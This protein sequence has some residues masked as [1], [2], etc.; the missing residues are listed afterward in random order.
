MKSCGRHPK[1]YV[2]AL[3][4]FDEFRGLLVG[5]STG[6]WQIWSIMSSKAEL[7]FT[8]AVPEN[9]LPV[10]HFGLVAPENDPHYMLY[11]WVT[12]SAKTANE[13]LEN[14]CTYASMYQLQFK[15]LVTGSQPGIND[16]YR[17]LIGILLHF[18]FNLSD[19]MFIGKESGEFKRLLEFDVVKKQV[20]GNDTY[21]FNGVIVTLD[22]NKYILTILFDLNA[23]YFA[24]MPQTPNRIARLSPYIS[25]IPLEKSQIAKYCC[26]QGVRVDPQSLYR[27]KEMSADASYVF[28]CSLNTIIDYHL[29]SR[30]LKAIYLPGGIVEDTSV[31]ENTQLSTAALN[32]RFTKHYRFSKTK[33]G[34]KKI[35]DFLISFLPELKIVLNE[36]MTP[37]LTGKPTG[38][39]EIGALR[40]LVSVVSHCLSLFNIISSSFEGSRAQLLLYKHTY[41]YAKTVLALTDCDILP[42]FYQSL[43]VKKAQVIPLLKGS[44][45]KLLKHVSRLE[46]V[47]DDLMFPPVTIT[48]LLNIF[49]TNPL[50]LQLQSLI[51][52]Y[53]LMHLPNGVFDIANLHILPRSEVEG[54][55][56]LYYLD[57]QEYD[58]FFRFL[59]RKSKVFEFCDI[60]DLVESLVSQG[61][62]AIA[63]RMLI[64]LR[65]EYSHVYNT[66]TKMIHDSYHSSDFHINISDGSMEVTKPFSSVLNET[67]SHSQFVSVL[68][69]LNDQERYDCLFV[70]LLHRNKLCDLLSVFGEYQKSQ[71]APSPFLEF[72]FLYTIK[73][74][75]DIELAA[76]ITNQNPSSF[77]SKF[78]PKLPLSS[79]ISNLDVSLLTQF[80]LNSDLEDIKLGSPVQSVKISKNAEGT[81]P[82][83]P[84]DVSNEILEQLRTPHPTPLRTKIM[85]EVEA[86]RSILRSKKSDKKNR[87]RIRFGE[88]DVEQSD[89]SPIPTRLSFGGV[90]VAGDERALSPEKRIRTVN[91]TSDVDYHEGVPVADISPPKIATEST[92][93]C[94]D[95]VDFIQDIPLNPSPNIGLE[96]EISTVFQFS[97]SRKEDTDKIPNVSLNSGVNTSTDEIS[98]VSAESDVLQTSD[99]ETAI[100]VSHSSDPGQQ[101]VLEEEEAIG[102]SENAHNSEELCEDYIQSDSQKQSVSNVVESKED[103]VIDEPTTISDKAEVS[104]EDSDKAEQLLL[105]KEDE[106]VICIESS[107]EEAGSEDYTAESSDGLDEDDI[108]EIPE[109]SEEEDSIKEDSEEEDEMSSVHEIDASLDGEGEENLEAASDEHESTFEVE[110]DDEECTTPP[111]SDIE[112]PGYMNEVLSDTE[113]RTQSIKP[114]IEQTELIDAHQDTSDDSSS[115]LENSLASDRGNVSVQE[116]SGDLSEDDLHESDSRDNDDIVETLAPDVEGDTCT[117]KKENEPIVES[118]PTVEQ[119]ANDHKAVGQLLEDECSSGN[120]E[121]DENFE[122]DE[123]EIALS[124]NHWFKDTFG[125][126]E[127]VSFNFSVPANAVGGGATT[128][129]KA[130]LLEFKNI[131]KA[132]EENLPARERTVHETKTLPTIIP[133]IETSFAHK[134][135]EFDPFKAVFSTPQQQDSIFG[136]SRTVF[137]PEIPTASCR[138][139]TSKS[140]TTPH[141]SPERRIRSSRP[142]VPLY[143]LKSK[144][145]NVFRMESA[146]NHSYDEPF[147]ATNATFGSLGSDEL[148]PENSRNAE[149]TK[150]K[151]SEDMQPDIFGTSTFDIFDAVKQ[152]VHDSSTAGQNSS[153]QPLKASPP[154]EV[155]NA[156]NARNTSMK[157]LTQSGGTVAADDYSLSNSEP[158]C[159]VHL[160]TE[161]ALDELEPPKS[162]MMS[163][164]GGE[165]L[166]SSKTPVRHVGST[167]KVETISSCLTK[168]EPENM[169]GIEVPGTAAIDVTHV[170]SST[171]CDPRDEIRTPSPAKKST[172]I[173]R[174]TRKA[175]TSSSYQSTVKPQKSDKEKEI[176]A[177][178]I[179]ASIR[180]ELPVESA[181]ALPPKAPNRTLRSARKTTGSSS[182]NQETVESHKMDDDEAI[183]SASSCN[184]SPVEFKSPPKT[185]AR[186]LRSTRKPTTSSN[187]ATDSDAADIPKI[188]T[189]SIPKIPSSNVSRNDPTDLLSSKPIWRT[190]RSSKN[191][192]K[193]VPTPGEQKSERLRSARKDLSRYTTVHAASPPGATSSSFETSNTTSITSPEGPVSTEASSPSSPEPPPRILRS[194]RR[195]INTSEMKTSSSGQDSVEETQ[196]SLK[197]RRKP[198]KRHIVVEKSLEP[199]DDA[200]LSQKAFSELD[201]DQKELKIGRTRRRAR[202]L[203]DE[204]IEGKPFKKFPHKSSDEDRSPPEVTRTKRLLRSRQ[205][206]VK[207][208]ND[209]K[210][211]PLRRK[212]PSGAVA[213]ENAPESKVAVRATRARKPTNTP[214]VLSPIVSE[215]PV[216][217]TRQ[218]SKNAPEMSTRSQKRIANDVNASP[219]KRKE[220]KEETSSSSA[221]ITRSSKKK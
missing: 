122:F 103:S 120:D 83:K 95:T 184:K 42:H 88:D 20:I 119:I 85:S 107:N 5:Y 59:P 134:D 82:L 208:T 75:S 181:N 37:M 63:Q 35:N 6:G 128:R 121:D 47:W 62:R 169:E 211:P 152:N 116:I 195:R 80:C 108:V 172:R 124:K 193:V 175:T 189:E 206:S 93:K 182:S 199:E 41:F 142:G 149:I 180:N 23:W 84:L 192:F 210:R 162:L 99:L 219:S 165:V 137:T 153:D 138:L 91:F 156:N 61:D 218:S 215:T 159:E 66:K 213:A 22:T 26:L 46:Q 51:V 8:F 89:A 7:W 3:A 68:K 94:S 216:R 217:R 155:R 104:L 28:P 147:I 220:I 117:A 131:Q 105:P 14:G 190:L 55:K 54:I 64:I 38:D 44:I 185:P 24:Q 212:K 188:N 173:L 96:N 57:N 167:H 202:K 13:F 144:G 29:G 101:N 136:N 201:E 123:P 204:N 113:V 109:S 197:S 143:V 36:T 2:T 135:E 48:S 43:Q 125:E 146:E 58:N 207:S 191:P 158:P 49:Y 70:F 97:P 106:D 16:K 34:R 196:I 139:L 73:H 92:V 157:E 90:E 171:E 110:D 163:Q 86:P 78:D 50:D 130:K 15:H 17:K 127:I 100:D 132:K 151:G 10:S 133:K 112:E 200:S 214:K 1:A 39:R 150:H 170:A 205:N 76:S 160:K 126:N 53:G 69:S 186:V 65:Q 166:K 74:F 25:Y 140:E 45:F 178:T 179:D 111:T 203:S 129:S 198:T 183:I 60:N 52:S 11:L 209:L 145:Q 114:D 187:S 71:T 79:Q 19:P 81:P 87:K 176:P 9:S 102:D 31:D 33:G 56:S 154:A 27:D 164:P 18:Q 221:R 168:D 118:V 32:G 115:G 141:G 21:D 98:F 194:S 30:H 12:Q 67:L 161:S 174:S 177:A 4:I 72:M 77:R 40:N 148:N